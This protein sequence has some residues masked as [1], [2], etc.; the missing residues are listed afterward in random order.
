MNPLILLI[1]DDLVSQ[2]DMRIKLQ[3]HGQP[4]EILSYDCPI[5]A[6]SWFEDWKS[7]NGALQLPDIL[8][9]DWQMPKMDGFEFLSEALDR[10]IPLK[11][12]DIYMA[13]SYSNCLERAEEEVKSVVKR[14]FIKPLSRAN[15]DII[16]TNQALKE[17]V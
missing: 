13:S 12:M 15:V 9:L 14:R 4:C 8:L 2:F 7:S 1:D 10:G 16:F 3:R 6:L 11:D 5:E 17:K